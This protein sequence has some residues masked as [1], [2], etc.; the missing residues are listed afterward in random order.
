VNPAHSGIQNIVFTQAGMHFTTP[1][2]MDNIQL[3]GLSLGLYGRGS[4]NF[5]MTRHSIF[6]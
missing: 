5:K 3:V 2:A 1:K 6:T 4:L